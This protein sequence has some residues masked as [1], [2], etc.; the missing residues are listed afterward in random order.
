MP[1]CITRMKRDRRETLS[2]TPSYYGFDYGLCEVTMPMLLLSVNVENPYV[3]LTY[4]KYGA[5]QPR[6]ELERPIPPIGPGALLAGYSKAIMKY[7][8]T[9]GFAF[10]EWQCKNVL[11]RNAVNNQV[12]GTY[13]AEPLVVAGI[14]HEHAALCTQ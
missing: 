11:L 1:T 5:P 8:S 3:G 10:N 12:R 2:A 7:Y 14:S 6:A 13:E 4:A 9:A